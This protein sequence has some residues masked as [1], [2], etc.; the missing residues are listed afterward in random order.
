MAFIVEPSRMNYALR[1]RYAV[2]ERLARRCLGARTITTVVDVET[3]RRH[4][5][6]VS[7]SKDHCVRLS[8]VIGCA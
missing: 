8:R 6:L 5:R 3:Q 2:V 4:T 1:V 7:A